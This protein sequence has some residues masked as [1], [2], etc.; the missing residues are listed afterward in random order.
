MIYYNLS[1]D[2]E[3]FYG[4][5]S[6]FFNL[7]SIIK[8]ELVCTVHKITNIDLTYLSGDFLES[9]VIEAVHHIVVVPAFINHRKFRER[10]CFSIS[11]DP[12]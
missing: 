5:M 7:L 8:L 3:R 12:D 1:L 11:I 10:Q 9:S 2:E 4:R 6:N